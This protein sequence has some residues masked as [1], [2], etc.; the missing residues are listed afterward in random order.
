MMA[1]FI[2]AKYPKRTST[3]LMGKIARRPGQR[4][5]EVGDLLARTDCGA[6][7]QRVNRLE[8]AV[9]VLVV[10]KKVFGGKMR[11]LTALRCEAGEDL[12]AGDGMA[13]VKSH[14]IV[15]WHRLPPGSPVEIGGKSTPPGR[16]FCG[17]AI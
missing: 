11:E 13:V 5:A 4:G 8:P 2:N 6:I 16:R 15:C 9:M 10:G 12:V 3:V 17:D 14:Y 7:R 1:L